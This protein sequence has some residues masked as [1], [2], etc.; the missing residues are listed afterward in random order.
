MPPHSSHTSR[1]QREEPESNLSQEEIDRLLSISGFIGDASQ[2]DRKSLIDEIKD[3]I[4]DSGKLSLDEWMGLRD[5]LKEIERLA[6][7]IDLIIE[8]KQKLKKK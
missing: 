5:R 8:L 2:P 6:P 7:H 4:L 3:A 1:Q